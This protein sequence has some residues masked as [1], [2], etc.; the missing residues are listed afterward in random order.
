MIKVS[1]RNTANGYTLYFPNLETENQ[2]NNS[3]D[4]SV[5][6]SLGN[7]RDYFDHDVNGPICNE[8]GFGILIYSA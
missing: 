7:F 1:M 4:G 2:R 3:V 6:I 5:R 8:F